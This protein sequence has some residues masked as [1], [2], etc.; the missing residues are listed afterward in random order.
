M[1]SRMTSKT[2]AYVRVSSKEQNIDRQIDTMRGLGIDDREMFIDRASGKDIER[3]QYKTLK[4]IIRDGDTVVF[5]SITR[6]S[7]NMTDIKNEYE[8]FN[9][10]GVNLQFVKEPM[11][12]T[13]ND[14][15]D[16]M[17]QAINDIILTIFGAFSQRERELIK[18]RQREGIDAA[19]ARGKHLGRPRVGLTEDQKE[20]YGKL[21][22]RWK[23]GEITATA[24]MQEMGLKRTTFY[25]K[26]KEYEMANK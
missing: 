19:K 22:P 9:K 8:W 14:K 4:A 15:S 25:S 13:T 20:K 10:S 12:N 21:Y 17:K 6:L 18:Q 2:F 26:V 16:V 1:V 23:A 7:R 5:D 11:L 24:M 3:H